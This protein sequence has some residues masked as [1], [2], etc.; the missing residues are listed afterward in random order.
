MLVM[1]QRTV[2][3]ICVHPQEKQEYLD[4]LKSHD[5]HI[6]YD[7]TVPLF[8]MVKRCGLPCTKELT[9]WFEETKQDVS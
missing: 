2:Y 4:M 8:D 1:H 9:V 6:V 7:E 3:N 5:Y